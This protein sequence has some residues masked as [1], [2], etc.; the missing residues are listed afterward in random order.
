MKVTTAATLGLALYVLGWDWLLHLLWCALVLS[1]G[2][3]LTTAV[4][5]FVL[6]WLSRRFPD[7]REAF[8]CE[9]A[10]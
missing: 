6:R 7:N 9:T 1:A 3:A 8:D 4:G 2:T 10:P 5:F